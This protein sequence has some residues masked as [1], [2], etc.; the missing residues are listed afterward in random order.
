[1]YGT[2]VG[3]QCGQRD[4][5]YGDSELERAGRFKSAAV[6]ELPLPN[7]CPAY[8]HVH[9]HVCVCVCVCIAGDL[10]VSYEWELQ[11]S[12][13]ADQRRLRQVHVHVCTTCTCMYYMNI[14]ACIHVLMRD[15]KEGR[16]R[17]KQGQK[18]NKAKQHSPPKLCLLI[19]IQVLSITAELEGYLGRGVRHSNLLQYLSIQHQHVEN[20]IT[21]EVC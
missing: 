17:S 3:V 8:L 1:M 6:I 20:K 5:L 16:R 12:K 15:E 7:A 11:C 14:R 18:N 9:V 13:R 19:H 2:C 10:L 21:V 4:L